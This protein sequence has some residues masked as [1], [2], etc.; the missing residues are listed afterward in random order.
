MP[1]RALSEKLVLRPSRKRVVAGFSLIVLVWCSVVLLTLAADPA[2]L[3][4]FMPM[5]LTGLSLFFTLMAILP[6]LSGETVV[7]ASGVTCR[8]GRSSD[9]YPWEQVDRISYAAGAFGC[10]LVLFLRTRKRIPLAGPS[11]GLFTRKRK[12]RA[13]LGPISA[14]A[15]VHRDRVTSTPITSLQRS[16]AVTINGVVLF[17]MLAIGGLAVLL[18]PPWKQAYW[19]GRDVASTLPSAC[20]VVDVA[21]MRRLVPQATA[22]N[23]DPGGERTTSCAWGTDGPAPGV[24]VQLEIEEPREF[25]LDGP[26]AHAHRLFLSRADDSCPT[27]LPGVGDEACSGVE[28]RPED[29]ARALV[30]ARKG[31]VLVTVTYAADRPAQA[32]QAQTVQLTRQALSRIRFE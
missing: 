13:R 22:P 16:A 26:E 27:R 8:N 25:D 5:A 32:V 19:P 4:L 18:S 7:D 24:D 30:V 23:G 15:G 3:I 12:L 28:N 20:S 9:H 2:R 31:N 17:V 29:P 1:A 11:A 10:R 21:T 6:R 14:W